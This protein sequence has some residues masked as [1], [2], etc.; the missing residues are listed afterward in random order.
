MF[1]DASLD[2]A[3]AEVIPVLD[4]FGETEKAHSLEFAILLNGNAEHHGAAFLAPNE[5]TRF[6]EGV[7]NGPITRG[8]DDNPPDDWSRRF[9]LKQLWPIADLIG[10]SELNS[11]EGLDPENYELKLDDY[12]DGFSLGGG[13]ARPIEEISPH[14]MEEF[15]QMSSGEILK[16]IQ[17]WV[18]KSGHLESVDDF[19][20]RESHEAR[21]GEFAKVLE[22][23]PDKMSDLDGWCDQVTVPNYLAVPLKRAVARLTQKDGGIEVEVPETLPGQKDW[24]NWFAMARSIVARDPIKE[25]EACKKAESGPHDWTWARRE[26]VSF[27]GAV[28]VVRDQVP[29]DLE[30]QIEILLCEIARGRDLV[31]EKRNNNPLE[32]W[33]SIA[34]NSTRGEAFGK[35]LNLEH[36]RK[37]KGGE[38]ELRLYDFFREELNR[39]DQSPA[40]FAVFG[41]NLRLAVFLYEKRLKDEPGLLLNPK[42]PDCCSAFVLSHFLYDNSWA[43]VIDTFPNLPHVALDTLAGLENRATP[44]NSRVDS[45]FGI[46]VGTHLAFYHWN[47]IFEP[48]EKG[49]GIV[50]RF[51]RLAAPDTRAGTVNAIGSIFR[52]SE[53]RED[54]FSDLYVRVMKIWERRFK[55]ITES[56]SKNTETSGQDLELSEFLS[57]IRCECFPFEWRTRNVLAA[58]DYLDELPRVWSE[59]EALNEYSGD[60][61]RLDA[62]ILIF[63]AFS[64][65]YCDNFRWSLH[66]VE[67]CQL[68]GRG[69]GSTNQLTREAAI[70]AQENLLQQELFEYRKIEAIS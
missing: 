61:D 48:D 20:K 13:A 64:D 29:D 36:D 25:T 65:R 37:K 58:L 26:T 49:V 42:M 68:L 21:A 14:S 63:K 10:G 57:W 27:L 56:H 3:R 19:Y 44:V 45:D 30:N 32:E 67:V 69:L 2:W 51:F 50:D 7:M 62:S 54:E 55:Q 60:P 35:L 47:Q 9:K 39:K 34:I 66:P 16:S 43:K 33:Y 53:D 70:A 6:F 1:P 41:A 17:S 59:V 28:S 22:S 12:K 15:G 18:P 31:L 38:S 4:R 11:Y 8:K 24:E 5:V 23:D 40:V 46:R 52:K